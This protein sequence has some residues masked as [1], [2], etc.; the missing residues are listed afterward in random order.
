MMFAS[1]SMTSIRSRAG[2]LIWMSGRAYGGSIFEIGD[3]SR[4]DG[5]DIDGLVAVEDDGK[6]ATTPVD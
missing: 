4:G 2:R 3:I 6:Q 1:D 5:K